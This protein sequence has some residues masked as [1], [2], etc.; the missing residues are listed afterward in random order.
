[1]VLIYHNILSKVAHYGSFLVSMHKLFWPNLKVCKL[2]YLRMFQNVYFRSFPVECDSKCTDCLPSAP[3]NCTVC[4]NPQL[5]IQDG[6]CVKRCR[7]GY[8]SSPTH[9]C[10]PCDETC[11][12]CGEGTPYHCDMCQPGLMWKHGQCVPQCGR[13]YYLQNGKCLG[14]IAL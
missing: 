7:L 1:M 5:Y 12:T 8:Y 10:L 2:Q 3:Q 9:R 13:G 11:Y 14:E 6:S 4:S